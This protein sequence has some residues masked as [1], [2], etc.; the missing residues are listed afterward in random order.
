[1]GVGYHP[2]KRKKPH[3]W[4]DTHL[5]EEREQ[6][7]FGLKAPPVDELVAQQVL[8]ALEPAAV[9]LSLQA[10]SLIQRERDR[11]HQHW[12]Q[13]LER[14]Q[15]E[16]QRGERQYQSVEPENRLVARKLGQQWE[17]SLRQE[18][19]L[20]EEYD[21]FLASTPTSLSEADAERIRAASQDISALWHAADIPCRFLTPGCACALMFSRSSCSMALAEA[22]RLLSSSV[23]DCPHHGEDALADCGREAGPCG[24]QFDQP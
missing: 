18:R 4:C 5:F 11:L 2:G 13:R 10:A 14:A 17:G 8:R 15:Y 24:Y 22:M 9:D 16:S 20:R 21:R 23:F 3:Y 6:P 1:M 7:C 12:R 19:Q